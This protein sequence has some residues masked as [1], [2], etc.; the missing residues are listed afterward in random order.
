MH[1]LQIPGRILLPVH[2]SSMYKGFYRPHSMPQYS[3]HYLSPTFVTIF[4][5]FKKYISGAESS[6]RKL[7][8]K[9]VRSGNIIVSIHVP[10]IYVVYIEYAVYGDH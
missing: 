9:P 2:Q 3:R 6:I 8:I 10:I 7:G 4:P 1:L 5:L